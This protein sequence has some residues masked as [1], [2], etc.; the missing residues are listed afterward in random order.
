MS[1]KR[2]EV[3]ERISDKDL[4]GWK[5]VVP[6]GAAHNEWMAKRNL[7]PGGSG[8]KKPTAPTQGGGGCVPTGF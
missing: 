2:W 1:V 6:A 7:T 8:G 5:V 4:L 3:G